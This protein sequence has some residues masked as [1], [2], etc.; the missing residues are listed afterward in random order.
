MDEGLKQMSL[1]EMPGQMQLHIHFQGSIYEPD[2]MN[3]HV[4]NFNS[5]SKCRSTWT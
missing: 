5:Q 2:V 1:F 4:P 3:K